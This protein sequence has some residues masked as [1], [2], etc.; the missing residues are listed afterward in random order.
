MWRSLPTRALETGRAIVIE[1]ARGL[2]EVVVSGVVEPDTY[3]VA[4]EELR[5]LEARVG[6][7]AFMIARDDNGREQRFELDPATGGSRVLNDDEVL[8]VARLV[9]DVEQHYGVPQD[10]EWAIDNGELFIVQSRP[11]TTLAPEV[12]DASALARPGV[13]AEVT[14]DHSS[15]VWAL[16]RV[17]RQGEYASSG[18]STTRRA[19]SPARCSW[20]R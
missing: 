14:G 2:G 19:S 15:L 12:L 9:R 4:K 18:R 10:I 11:I 17:R 7:Q 8:D 20:R 5:L 1:G 3:V 16:R 13:P 6:H